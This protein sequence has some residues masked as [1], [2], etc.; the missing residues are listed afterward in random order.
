MKYEDALIKLREI[1]IVMQAHGDTA[2]RA[3]RTYAAMMELYNVASCSDDKV[4]MEQ[5]RNSLHTCLDSI[6]DSGAMLDEL[7]REQ[8]VI[9]NSVTDLPRSF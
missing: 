4:A 1:A 8:R 9:A 2:E 6:L 5:H 7:R 3:G